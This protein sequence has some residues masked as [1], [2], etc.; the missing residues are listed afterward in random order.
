MT[1]LWCGVV[2]LHAVSLTLI[3]AALQ[4]LLMDNDDAGALNKN[5]DLSAAL[6]LGLL[7]Y[8]KDVTKTVLLF[9]DFDGLLCDELFETSEWG[10]KDHFQMVAL[11]DLLDWVTGTDVSPKTVLH[12]FT[13]LYKFTETPAVTARIAALSTSKY[14]P[15]FPPAGTVNFTDDDELFGGQMVVFAAS[16]FDPNVNK[17]EP[18]IAGLLYD[19]PNDGI[20]IEGVNAPAA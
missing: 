10:Y 19:L 18:L 5:F 9:C 20:K 6:L 2:F 12:A 16:P 15:I 17:N 3:A 1:I 8:G 13:K 14:H 4:T 7:N 11:K